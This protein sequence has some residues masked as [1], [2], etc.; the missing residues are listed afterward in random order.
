M[1]NILKDAYWA[2]RRHKERGLVFVKTVIP[3]GET[4]NIGDEAYIYRNSPIG[5]VTQVEGKYMVVRMNAEQLYRCGMAT[6]L[7]DLIYNKG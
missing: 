7:L 4:V 1:K 2:V 6:F 3:K 5:I